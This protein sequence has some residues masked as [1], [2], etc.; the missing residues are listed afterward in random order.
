M[1]NND[2]STLFSETVQH[3]DIWVKAR[4]S[5][6]D[7]NKANKLKFAYTNQNEHGELVDEEGNIYS[8]LIMLENIITKEVLVFD[9]QF[10]NNL[11]LQIS[12]YLNSGISDPYETESD[13]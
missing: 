6:A 12:S 7:L 1:S 4:F 13:E 11:G 3:I 8:P 5:V 10:E 9:S 2:S